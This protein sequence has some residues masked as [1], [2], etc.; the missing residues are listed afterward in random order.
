MEEVRMITQV[1]AALLGSKR[2]RDQAG[3]E[4]G[5]T[6]PLL[7]VCD[8]CN[9]A[10]PG[11]PGEVCSS[12]HQGIGLRS[13][14]KGTYWGNEYYLRAREQPQRCSWRYVWLLSMLALYSFWS[15]R[16]RLRWGK[17]RSLPGR[18][19]WWDLLPWEWKMLPRKRW[20]LKTPY[21]VLGLHGRVRRSYRRRTKVIPERGK[22]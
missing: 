21:I 14:E 18:H 5:P 22:I 6:R 1:M 15:Y 4:Q 13:T 19:T 7:V 16:W 3:Q 10:F 12:C 20:S 11:G 17:V 8:R 2:C 9:Y